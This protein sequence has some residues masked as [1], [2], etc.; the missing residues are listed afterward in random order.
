[1]TGEILVLAE[2]R[3]GALRDVTFELLSLAHE[4]SEKSGL[5]VS[6][7][8]LGEEVGGLAEALCKSADKVLLAEHVD[9]T[10]YNAAAYLPIL[11]DLIGI[12]KP[13][14]VLVAHTA[15][16]MDLAPALA[17]RAGLP[18]ASDCLEVSL[19]GDAVEVSR[20]IYGGKIEARL[21]LAPADGYA[22][23]IR[24]GCFSPSPPS[25]RSGEIKRWVT[26]DDST[27]QGRRF[28]DLVAAQIEDIDI[29]DADILV[30]VGRGVGKEDN[31]DTVKSFAD[32]IGATL[33][34]SRPVADKGWLPKS[35]QVG[36]SGKVVR[37]KVYIALGVSGA[38]QHLAGMRGADTIIAVNT[39]SAAPIF[40]VAHY[41][42]VAD[43]FDVLPVL[44][45]RFP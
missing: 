23:T 15:A 20:Q 12:G 21:R 13:A 2:H 5:S 39:D 36:T 32:A 38:Y 16:G 41:G 42:I 45:E 1:M 19:R 29:A 6:V 25:D 43:M 30:S 28:L 27:L 33:C 9:L 31:L 22:L 35:R 37:P 7:A 8:L 11:T 40:D 10:E 24:P 17:V 4:L 18:A 14:L 26:H 34:C 44:K 3:N